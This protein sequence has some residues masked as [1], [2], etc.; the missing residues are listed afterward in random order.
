MSNLAIEIISPEGTIFSGNCH[1][2]VVPSVSGDIGFMFGHE[3]VIALLR[4]GQIS[5][6]D[7][8]QNIIKQVNIVSGSAE[9]E[10]SGKLLVLVDNIS[11]S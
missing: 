11:Q 1:M 3:A 4:E 5:L 7:S 6:F 9:I 2:A 8:A 10:D